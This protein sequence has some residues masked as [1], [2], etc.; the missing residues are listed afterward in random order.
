MDTGFFPESNYILAATG[1]IGFA[2][3]SYWLHML[4]AWYVTI[5]MFSVLSLTSVWFHIWRSEIAYRLDNSTALFGVLLSLYECYT[6]GP[7]ALGIGILTVLYATLVFYIG[8]IGKCYAFDQ[9]RMI[10]TFF[11]ASMHIVMGGGMIFI[12]F[13]FPPKHNEAVSDILLR[14]EAYRALAD[15]L[16]G[17]W[18]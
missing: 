9:N 2:A 6:R 5:M 15:Y 18:F 1:G 3:V 14:A 16:F 4:E 17:R 13:F 11:H 10:S 12:A 8:H 7:M